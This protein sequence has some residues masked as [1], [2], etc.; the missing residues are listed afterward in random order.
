VW[1]FVSDLAVLVHN[2]AVQ[3][4][5]P[6][7]RFNYNSKKAA[8][9]AGKGKNPIQH[10]DANG[11][12]FHPNVKNTQKSSSKQVSSHDHYYYPKNK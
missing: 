11:P 10:T 12:H 1:D 9:Q 3:R 5:I 4:K 7:S 8:K 2:K 6:A